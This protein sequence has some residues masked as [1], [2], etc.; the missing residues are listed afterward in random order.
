MI[1]TRL[2][3]SKGEIS[4][5]YFFPDAPTVHIKGVYFF[6]KTIS[7]IITK[8]H[9]PNHKLI[10]Y[11]QCERYDLQWINPTNYLWALQKIRG[12]NTSQLTHWI[13]EQ[14][15]KVELH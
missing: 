14:F 1:N 15:K 8:T 10:S 11:T 3:L 13:D 6:S 7:N 4:T 12:N 2:T 9:P 5:T